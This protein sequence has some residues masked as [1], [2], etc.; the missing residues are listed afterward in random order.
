MK[1]RH[2]K[3]IAAIAVAGLLSIGAGTRI[4]TQSGWRVI[5]TEGLAQAKERGDIALRL[6]LIDSRDQRRRDYRWD[7]TLGDRSAATPS[8]AID[9]GEFKRVLIWKTEVGISFDGER[10]KRKISVG[11]RATGVD[12][13]YQYEFAWLTKEPNKAPEPTQRPVTIRAEPRIAPGRVVA[14][15]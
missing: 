15:L 6:T 14:H 1:A 12:G 11:Q 5:A 2:W 3:I 4:R 8:V 13:I 10:F 9:C 7:F